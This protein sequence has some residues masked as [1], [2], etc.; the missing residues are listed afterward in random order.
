MTDPAAIP[1]VEPQ[2]LFLWRERALRL[3]TEVGRVVIGQERVIR[4]LLIALLAHGHVLLEGDVGVGKTT[5]LRAMARGVGGPYQRVEG[6]VDLMPTDLIYHAS[7]GDD[8]RPRLEPGALLRHGET[9]AVFFFNEINRARP[10]VHALL[11][12]LMAE[13]S[14]TAFNREFSLPYVVIFADRN[15]LERDETFDLPAAA[16][17][18][19]FFE[20]NVSMPTDPD[21]RRQLIFDRRF[22]DT[23]TLVAEI[24]EGLLD[25]RALP[26]LARLIQA[27]VTTSPALEEYVLSLW[28]ALRDPV[29]AGIALPD[30][31]MSRL[32]KG[33]ASPRGMA[34]LVRAAHVRAW[35][36]GRK[37]VMPEDVR[38]VFIE[39]VAHR[40]FVDPI[41]LLRREAIVRDLC[42]AILEKVRAP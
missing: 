15:S 38:A 35:L 10:Q 21:A 37:T 9:L 19:F 31:D 27:E 32:V 42:T 36:E 18:R 8:G 33:G 30:I 4:F 41:Y 24:G 39:S 1:V 26:A 40:I 34:Y 3:E 17:D 29:A 20:V 25:Y 13:R 22:H 5:L 12:R 28:T 7:I 23:D 16:R 14:L 2:D 11:L 6:T